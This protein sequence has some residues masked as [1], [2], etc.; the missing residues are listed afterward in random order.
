[1]ER[2]VLT[3]LVSRIIQEHRRAPTL[4]SNM[5]EFANFLFISGGGRFFHVSCPS[6][7]PHCSTCTLRKTLLGHC[8]TYTSIC[9]EWV[10]LHWGQ[11]AHFILEDDCFTSERTGLICVLLPVSLG[12]SV[13]A[14]T[15]LLGRQ[16]QLW[17]QVGTVVRIYP[18]FI[19]LSSATNPV[20]TYT[21]KQ[22]QKKVYQY[23]VCDTGKER[24]WNG[25]S[26]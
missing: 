14:L 26:F 12:A 20:Q 24:L 8:A 15:W 6:L 4:W 16:S 23:T 9:G 19:L 10:T 13:R 11:C 2:Q 1:M 17:V 5:L 18:A 3:L 7:V 25:T 21:W 22:W